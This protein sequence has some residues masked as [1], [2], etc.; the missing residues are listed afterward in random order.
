MSASYNLVSDIGGTNSR[1]ALCQSG[2]LALV[3]PRKYPNTDFP[4]LEEAIQHYIND[5]GIQPQS[6]CLAVAGPAHGEFVQLTNIDWKFSV[7]AMKERFDFK[8]LY[9]VNDFTALAMSVPH[10]SPEN[11]R[12][13]GDEVPLEN[14]PIAVLG[15][16]TGLGVSGLL[17]VNNGWMPLQGEGGNVAFTP[18]TDLEIKLLQR[19]MKDKDFVR[20]EDF[21]SGTGITYLHELMLE[22]HGDPVETVAA[23]DVVWRAKTSDDSL[24]R[25]TL[26]VFC[27]MLGNFAG[28]TA[29]T[30]GAMGGVYIGGG[31]APQFG[32]L[33]FTSPFRKA[34]EER[35]RFSNY[36]KPIPT[37]VLLSHSRAALLG[38]AAILQQ[39]RSGI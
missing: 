25:R 4:S 19:A 28:D 13:V 27:G 39:E 18:R 16:G 5:V 20:A 26:N 31:V 11:L 35:G 36:V 2:S 29:L 17:P 3:E 21:I 37:Y 32:E 23:K 34:F 7:S 33:F 15:P 10:E 1:F 30:L 8:Q 14:M 22:L 12:Q 6:A 9:V 24:S 38:A